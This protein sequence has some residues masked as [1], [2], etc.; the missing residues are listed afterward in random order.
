MQAALDRI[1][2]NR[3]TITIA[4]R[5]STIKKADKI[6]V[7]KAG[8][9]VE[10]GSHDS[11][12]EHSNGVY[13]GFVNSQ[14]LMMLGDQA[15]AIEEELPDL[16]QTVSAIPKDGRAIDDPE[17][18]R[19]TPDSKYKRKGF[20]STVGLLLYEQKDRYFLYIL[21]LLAAMGAACKFLFALDPMRGTDIKPTK[22]PSRCS[23]I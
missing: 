10:E 5:L 12:L 1:S 2:Q 15:S 18:A 16:D 13:H 7:M 21:I 3:T 11:L 22:P 14:Q 20:F 6:V 19:A 9:I 23:P 17:A 4:H 8:A